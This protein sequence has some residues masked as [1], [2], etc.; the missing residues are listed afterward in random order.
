MIS[1]QVGFVNRRGETLAGFL[2][3][4]A[5]GETRVYAVLAHCFT[6]GKDLKPFENVASA[7]AEEGIGLFRFDFAGLGGSEGDFSRSTLASNVGDLIDAA[8]FLEGSF[9]GPKLLI[10]HSLGGV[11][12]LQ[13][14]GDIASVSCVVTIGTPANPGHLGEKLSRTRDE[15]RSAGE[16]VVMIGG[17]KF[18]LRREFFEQLEVTRVE[19][20]LGRLNKALLVLHSPVDE[21]VGIE[22]AAV[23]FRS[24]RHPKSF[25]SLGR[26]DHLL[27]K[28][29]DA[30][31]AGKVISAW[32]GY[33]L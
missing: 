25:V 32:A 3:V 15:A 24:A 27:L 8:D 10:G 33:Y 29:E 5:A 30:R 21:T 19:A 4:P 28:A 14:A 6:C 31:Y 18:S 20:V 23:I 1:K 16:A 9:A 26:A 7:L 2:D 17:K 22:N 12:A 11:A 13:A